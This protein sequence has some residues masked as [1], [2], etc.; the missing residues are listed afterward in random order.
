MKSRKSGF[1]LIELLVVVSI[2]ALLVSILLPA[3]SGAREQA[4][5]AVCSVHISGVGK[6]V[7]IYANDTKDLLPSQ[8]IFKSGPNKGTP[9]IYFLDNPYSANYYT[10]NHY[11]TY[12]DDGSGPC[13]FGCLYLSGSLPNDS[14]VVFCPSFRGSHMAEYAGRRLNISGLEYNSWNARGNPDHW[15]YCGINRT[16]KSDDYRETL[17]D[18]FPT[19]VYRM[20][21]ADE[22]KIGWLNLRVSYGVRPMYNL[23]IK[24]ISQ[25][26]SGMS[27]LSDVWMANGGWYDIH[28]DEMSHV[29]KGS[30]EAKMHA[31]YVDGHVERKTFPREKYFACASGYSPLPS[32]EGGFMNNGLNWSKLTWRV[33]FEDGIDDTTGMPYVFP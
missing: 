26:K 4:K 14:D 32:A 25:M 8:G 22:A 15:N 28:I 29:S 12:K 6:A 21:A 33:L 13:E 20:T 17:T 9:V 19:D 18:M 3:L 1:T 10:Y 7:A 23:R 16:K 2:I 30:T 24:R 27:Y 31:C 5:M 11:P